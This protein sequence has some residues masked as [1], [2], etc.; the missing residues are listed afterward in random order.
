M[1]KYF[2]QLYEYRF[3]AENVSI[4][5]GKILLICSNPLIIVKTFFFFISTSLF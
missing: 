5:K 1:L 2:K 4:I 3:I